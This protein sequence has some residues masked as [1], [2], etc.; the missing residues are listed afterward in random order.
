MQSLAFAATVPTGT[1]IVVRTN[2]AISTHSNPGQHFA[3]TLDKGVGGLPA[4]T[5]VT[6]LIVTS[7]AR[8]TTRSNPLSLTLTSV[9]VKGREIQIKTDSVEPKGAKTTSTKRGNFSFGEDIFPVGTKLE[10]RLSQPA[11]L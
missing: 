7:R 10:F 11:N 1:A 3:G 5:R 9:S 8:A 2:V 6:G 4:G